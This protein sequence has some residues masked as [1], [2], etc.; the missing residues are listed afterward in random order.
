MLEATEPSSRLRWFY[1]ASLNEKYMQ[2]ICNEQIKLN[3]TPFNI[4]LSNLYVIA[5]LDCLRA[6]REGGY[7][8]CP[9]VHDVEPNCR[10]MLD[11]ARNVE[12][13]FLRQS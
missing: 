10:K 1:K 3:E 2:D 7:E 6:R 12:L 9:I 11:F 5:M 13:L 4:G 8:T